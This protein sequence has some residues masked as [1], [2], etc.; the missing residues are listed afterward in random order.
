MVLYIKL[1]FVALDQLPS[2]QNQRLFRGVKEDLNDIYKQEPHVV[3]WG[4]SS[5]SVSESV[6]ESEDF[7]GKT[8]KRTKFVIECYSGKSIRDYSYI[9]KED[10][11]LVLPAT[12]FEVMKI[13]QQER[14]FHVIYLKEVEPLLALQKSVTSDVS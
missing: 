10:E 6:L 7:C 11:V 13:V 1:L 2:I 4:F 3:W 14:N 5:C 8:G 12:E 9:S